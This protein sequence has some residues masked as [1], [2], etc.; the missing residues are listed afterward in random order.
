[1]S[2]RSKLKPQYKFANTIASTGGRKLKS[3]KSYTDEAYASINNSLI[4]GTTLPKKFQ[5]IVDDLDA[6]FKDIP[7][8]REEIIVYRG[9][10]RKHEF[11]VLSGFVSTSYDYGTALGFADKQKQCCVFIIKVP[12]GAKV[13]PVEELSMN[14]REGE[15]L[16]PRSGY[17]QAKGECSRMGMECFNLELMLEPPKPKSSITDDQIVQ[18]LISNTSQD[19][20]EL[21]GLEDAI[22]SVATTLEKTMG[23]SINEDIIKKAI[24]NFPIPV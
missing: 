22:R 9:V 6:I 4:Y 24:I 12:A 7:P 3:V 19:E 18:L 5:E 13:L 16:L 11:G 2:T 20:I 14:S 15:I 23:N 21:F 17:F 8:T 10:T 1:M